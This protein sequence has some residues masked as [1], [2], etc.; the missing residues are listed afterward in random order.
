MAPQA[1]RDL[2]LG[3]LVRGIVYGFGLLA[4][5]FLPRFS[6]PLAIGL[7]VLCPV[8]DAIVRRIW[9]SPPAVE[10]PKPQPPEIGEAF[11]VGLTIRDARG[12]VTGR[13]HGWLIFSEGWILF[14]GNRSEFAITRGESYRRRSESLFVLRLE[15]GRAVYLSPA[16]GWDSEKAL[17]EA[18]KTWETVPIPD[19]E[20]V[21]PPEEVHPEIVAEHQLGW[22]FGTVAAAVVLAFGIGFV[23]WPTIALGSILSTG[24]VLG[25]AE[26]TRRLRASLA[27]ALLDRSVP[28]PSM[29]ERILPV[30]R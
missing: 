12:Q 8:L 10:P 2:G 14:E 26:C 9:K 27:R 6:P 21:L 16:T 23:S 13:D 28:D 18:F 3:F 22:I 20:A 7:L 11:R 19:G 17:N 15:D 24:Y 30:K 5:T 29:P 1:K 4:G 25:A